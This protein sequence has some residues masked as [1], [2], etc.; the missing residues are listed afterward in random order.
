MG[1]HSLEQQPRSPTSP[2]LP[3]SPAQFR[4][5]S[6]PRREQTPVGNAGNASRPLAFRQLAEQ[7]KQA[8][9]SNSELNLS[10]PPGW[11][12]VGSPRLQTTEVY[13]RDRHFLAIGSAALHSPRVYTPYMPVAPPTPVTPHL[14]TRS[15]RRQRE[16]EERA[17]R[18]AITEEEQVQDEKD[19]WGDA[20]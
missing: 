2:G 17:I 15:E 20:Y 1:S 13:T 12:S 11:S 16:K 10:A 7:Q 9:V 19:M 8:A 3:A 14:T 4:V 6:P 18:G 5:G